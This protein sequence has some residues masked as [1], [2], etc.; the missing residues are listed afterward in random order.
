[1]THIRKEVAI[2]K[3]LSHHPHITPLVE[4][5]DD[6][7]E[8]SFYLGAVRTKP[9]CP[10]CAR[11]FAR[12]ALLGGNVTARLANIP[13]RIGKVHCQRVIHRDIKPA[14]IMLTAEDT[15]QIGDFG[16]SYV[17]PEGKDDTLEFAKTASPPFSPPE[18]CCEPMDI[19]SSGVTLYCFVHGRCPFEDD[20]IIELFRKIAEEPIQFSPTLS[21]PLLDFLQKIL[22][23]DPEKRITI[24]QMRDHPWV[25][26]GGTDPMVSRDENCRQ[27]VVVTEEDVKKAVRPAMSF[28]SKVRSAPP[29]NPPAGA[30]APSRQTASAVAAAA[31]ASWSVDALHS[32][33]RELESRQARGRSSNDTLS[34]PL[35][36]DRMVDI[37]GGDKEDALLRA[38]QRRGRRKS[39]DQGSSEPV[40]AANNRSARDQNNSV[41]GLHNALPHVPVL[42]VQKSSELLQDVRESSKESLFQ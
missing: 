21:E 15:A 38:P 35:A 23:K 7:K 34:G 29:P 24:A 26:K 19:W 31:S 8:D 20:N 27:V 1:M 33:G 39:A 9:A 2:L 18:S 3:K 30:A 22:C 6:A 36:R 37:D 40:D 13:P 4:V 17:I 41:P 10:A 16:V 32:K 11:I 12:I 25:T 42:V 28:I 14:N 5:L